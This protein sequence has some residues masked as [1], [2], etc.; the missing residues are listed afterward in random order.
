MKLVSENKN[1]AAQVANRFAYLERITVEMTNVVDGGVFHVRIIDKNSSYAKI[2]TA[3]S[4]F[5]SSKVEELE[6][7]ILKGTMCAARFSQDKKWY[8]AKVM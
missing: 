7:P 6:K 3:M 1:S 4:Q 8:R 5:E 2:D